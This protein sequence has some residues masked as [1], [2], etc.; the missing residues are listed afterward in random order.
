MECLQFLSKDE[1]LLQIVQYQKTGEISVDELPAPKI[2]PGNVLVRNV[3][4]L[5]SSGTE[6]TSVET[7]QASMLRKARLRPDLV[8]QVIDH[9]HRDGLL[10]TFKKVHYR[11][12]NFKELG[13]SSAGVVVESAVDDIKEGDRV[14]CA[15]VG[16]AAH[17][18]IVSVP[19]NLLVKIPN[20]VGF[21]EAAFTTVAAVAMQGVRQADIRVGEQVV[22]IG[23]GLIGLITVQLLKASGCRVI[24]LDVASCNFDLALTLGCDRCAISS[25][26]ALPEVHSFTR[27]YGADAVMITAATGS[28]EPVELAIECARKRGTVVA[29]GTVG[30]NIPRSPFYEKEINFRISCSYGPGRYDSSYEEHGNDYPLAYVRWTENR[31]MEAVLDMVAQRK[32]NLSALISHR[33]PLDQS[34]RAYNIITGKVE[35]S[36]LGILIQYSDPANPISIS[37][38]VELRTSQREPSAQRAALGFIG[39]GNFAQSVL[40]PPLMKLAP[41]MRGVA[42]TRPVN[43][44]NAARKYG[45]EFYATDAAEIINDKGV[46]V[47]FVTSRHDSHARFVAQSL[48][49]RKSVFVEK[50]L[51]LDNAELEGLLAA[52]A[53]CELEGTVPLLMVGYNR[54]FSEPIRTIERLFAG[55]AEPLAMHYRVNAGFMPLTHWIQQPEQGGRIVG[56]AGHF[57]DVMQ[58]LCGALPVSVHAVAPAD[59]ARRYRNDNVLI[60]LTFADG[61]VGTIHYLANGADAIEKE[62]LEVFGDQKTARM[63]NFKKL[64]CAAGRKR[65]V[66]LFS[67]E[68]GHAREMKALLESFES[69]SGS[70]IGI[71]SLAAT[72]RA[73]FAVMESLRTGR[74][75]RL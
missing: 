75:I 45:F 23:L 24:G 7:A 30:M 27:G 64:E 55:R 72:S 71:E 42:T 1:A 22:V 54:R 4:S 58:F 17:A 25:R 6:R 70:P 26:D 38:R 8:R 65:S 73:T 19:R 60:T 33:I 31:N 16:Y 34:L 3:F 49:A 40:M 39:A 47:I 18:E 51:A 5:I 44:K 13:Y 15:G 62:Y 29:V 66:K 2:R 68:K 28:N 32:L 35:E 37:R 10:A 48:R 69:G 63:W 46:N 56:E 41:R 43:A 12:D 52:Y 74:V 53:E 14:A 61:S 59:T 57:V 67:G 20:E 11:L 50:P 9:V 21:D 36:Y